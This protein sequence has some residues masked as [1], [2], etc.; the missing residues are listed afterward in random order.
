MRIK[1]KNMFLTA[2]ILACA[3]TAVSIYLYLL[4]AVERATELT[5][6]RLL[7]SVKEQ[8]LTF[9]AK[10]DGQFSVLETMVDSMSVNELKDN[11]ALI[12]KMK[13]VAKASPFQNIGRADPCTQRAD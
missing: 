9:D 2:L 3:I 5:N 7:D 12:S 1:R 13:S 4:D 10:M 11:R 8:S 6:Q